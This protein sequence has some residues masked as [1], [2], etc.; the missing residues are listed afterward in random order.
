MVLISYSSL[1]SGSSVHP[2]ECNIL[3]YLLPLL[4]L[5]ILT[6]F[7]FDAANLPVKKVRDPVPEEAIQLL[8]DVLDSIEVPWHVA[9]ADAAAEC[10]AMER[11]SI[12]DAV[13]SEEGDAI[14]YGCSNLIRFHYEEGNKKSKAQFRLYET[15]KISR[16]LPGM[17]REGFVLH[18]IL[19][20]LRFFGTKQT[21]ETVQHRDLRSS[22]CQISKEQQLP[23]WRQR[24]V[25]CLKGIKIDVPLDFPAYS[26]VEKYSKPRISSPETLSPFRELP[27]VAIDEEKLK[28]FLL[29]TLD[30]KAEKYVKWIVPVLVVRHLL[31][32]K[33]GKESLNDRFKLELTSPARDSRQSATFLLSEATS[34]D[35]STYPPTLA[36]TNFGIDHR[37]KLETL[38]YILERGCPNAVTQTA[39]PKKPRAKPGYRTPRT[40][41]KAKSDLPLPSGSGTKRQSTLMDHFG[42]SKRRRVASRSVSPSPIPKGEKS[43]AKSPIKPSRQ[44]M[45]LDAGGN[46]PHL[47]PEPHHAQLQEP[48]QAIIDVDAGTDARK[49][50][51]DLVDGETSH[52][53]SDDLPSVSDLLKQGVAGL[54]DD[55]SSHYDSDDLPPVA[56]L[57]QLP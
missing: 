7:V 4:Q 20:G 51:V 2:L 57:L 38:P 14:L 37:A 13:W 27:N 31:Q 12:A 3:Y 56:E 16:T 11:A 55:A 45:D 8:K 36:H 34:L 48:P 19:S 5:G 17:D 10:A 54:A 1:A 32:T 44:L 29:Q 47:E 50:V 23:A 26:D 49:D 35:M 30:F 42:V 22:L 18:E 9:P 15:A 53:D 43:R 28:N 25:Q 6:H 33:P 52:Y 41:T 24:L 21:L 46:A 39:S 40:P